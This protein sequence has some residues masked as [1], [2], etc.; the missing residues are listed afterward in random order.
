MLGLV[1]LFAIL[2]IIFGIWGFGAAAATTW[3]GVQVLF[4]VFIALLVLSLLGWG[5]GYWRRRPLP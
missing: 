3:V 1:I 2:A 5:G 4:W